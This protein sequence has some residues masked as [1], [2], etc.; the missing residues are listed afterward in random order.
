VYPVSEKEEIILN[1][2]DFDTV[3][4]RR[5]T[6]SMKW[7]GNPDEGILPMWVADMDFAAPPP[8][9]EAIK[10]RAESGIFGYTVPST[11]YHEAICRWLRIRHNTEVKAEWI[12]FGPGVVPA[13]NMLIRA[14][15]RPGDKVIIQKPV[16]YPFFPSIENNHCQIS[17]NPLKFVDGQYFMDFADLEIKAK[18]PKA[19]VMILCSPHNP[20]GRVW[21][22]E[23]LTTLG[24][25]CLRNNVIVISDEIHHDLIF[26]EY[27]H[28][29]FASISEAFARN[30]VVCTAPS[31][32]FNLAG[33]QTSAIIIPDEGLRALYAEVLESNFLRRPNIFGMV[34]L[35]AAYRHGEEWLE[36]L[37][38]YLQE[39][40]D[41]LM[42][43]I[44]RNLPQIKVIKPQGTYLAWMDFRE[45]GLRGKA[46]ED[47][48]LGK[49]KLWLD[50]GYIFG[51]AGDGFERINLACPRATLSR[52]LNQ[53]N[54]AVGEMVKL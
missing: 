1:K 10:K 19:K 21:S 51:S 12:K 7:D 36:Q 37:L 46:L 43:F 14:Y 20:V 31:K 34:A 13:I 53:L 17:D 54:S 40:R 44:A 18:D 38:D 39:N 11:G 47:F 9:V 28:T 30:S 26:R 41:Y 45:L 25:I 15:T 52:A 27:R 48:M 24:D 50:E 33:L 22:R 49:A 2:Y 3:I 16:Y 8:V 29:V 23:E 6:N 42:E 35:E 4:E 32:T 5:H